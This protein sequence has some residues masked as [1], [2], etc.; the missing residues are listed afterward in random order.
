MVVLLC[1]VRRTVKTSRL[2]KRLLSSPARTR[3]LVTKGRVEH[4]GSGGLDAG[5]SPGGAVSDFQHRAQLD[6]LAFLPHVG[7]VGF[8]RGVRLGEGG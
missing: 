2:K 1:N 8:R 4:R 6:V 3:L 7:A 5:V